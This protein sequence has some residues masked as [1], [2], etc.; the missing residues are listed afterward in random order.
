MVINKIK[1][2]SF[3][4]FEP[5][6]NPAIFL[7]RGADEKSEYPWPQFLAQRGRRRESA[8][9]LPPYPA[10]TCCR[11]HAETVAA[12]LCAESSEPL[13]YIVKCQLT[14][15]KAFFMYAGILFSQFIRGFG[16]RKLAP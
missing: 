2:E 6:N 10:V 7:L 13:S 14:F 11:R 4:A 3:A 1:V 15:Y 8:L 9:S 12:S 5:K 16:G